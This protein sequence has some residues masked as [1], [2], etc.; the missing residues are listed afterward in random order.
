MLLPAW[1]WCGVAVTQGRRQKKTKKY[2]HLVDELEA[3]LVHL[4]VVLE[5]D[6]VEGEGGGSGEG[7]N[8]GSEEGHRLLKKRERAK[9]DGC[10]ERQKRV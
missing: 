7:D 3:V 5:L 4:A 1:C 8:A 6:G 10:W 2:T 9:R